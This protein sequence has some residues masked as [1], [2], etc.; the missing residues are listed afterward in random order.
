[1]CRLS[2][3]VALSLLAKLATGKVHEPNA[4]GVF[5]LVRRRFAR[6]TNLAGPVGTPVN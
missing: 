6:V 2:F 3:A 1:M 5:S 4:F